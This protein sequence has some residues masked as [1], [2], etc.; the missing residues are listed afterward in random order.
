MD[1]HALLKEV[2]RLLV[3]A[4]GLIAFAWVTP[5]C[6]QYRFETRSTD[7]GL[8][9]NTV[10]AILQ[11]RDG[12]MWFTTS[13]GLV[14][15]D[16]V[17]FVVFDK[18]TTPGLGSN[19]FLS[20]YEDAD[21][22]L[23]AGTADAGVTQYQKGVFHTFSV[24]DGLPNA[25]VIG[26]CDDER[27][28]VLIWTLAGVV[29][30]H[31]GR[32]T[33]YAPLQKATGE[34]TRVLFR[35]RNGALWFTNGAVLWRLAQENLQSY[36]QAEGLD[37]A[38][39][40]SGSEDRDGRI[41]IATARGN[42]FEL[43]GE[44]F[45]HISL[46]SPG[47]SSAIWA[48][49]EDAHSNIVW[50]AT[51][52][53]LLRLSGDELKL[54]TT[55][56]GLPGN[57][58]NTL[59][60]DREGSL[61]VGTYNRG[62]VR[63]RAQAAQ[64]LSKDDGL[65]GNNVYPIVEDPTGA[66]WIGTWDG[67]LSKYSNGKFTSFHQPS[68]PK[69]ITALQSDHQGRLWIGIWGGVGRM[70]DDHFVNLTATLGV[71][72]H[73]VFAIFEDRNGDFWFGTRTGLYRYSGAGPAIRYGT[74]DG[75]ASD[76]VRDII[77]DRN[78]DIWIGSY[79]G[80]TRWHD[81]KFTSLTTKDGLASNTVR[82]LYEDAAGTLWIGTYDGGL[83]RFRDGKFVNYTTTDGLFSNGIFR[84]LED[85]RGNF[86][87]SCNRGIFRVRRDQL[88]DF[89]AGRI[90]RLTCVPYGKED[91]LAQT[92]CNG[93]QQPA[94]IKT[95]DGKLWFPTQGG[96]V[97]IDPNEV[98]T[99]SMAPPVV[100]E[101]ASLDRQPVLSG[102]SLRIDPG[103]ENLEIRYTGLSFINSEHVAFRYRME[104]LENDWVEAGARRTAQYA[105]LPPGHYTFRVIAANA[106]GVWN[107][108][109][110]TLQIIVVPP[111]WRTWWFT[112]MVGVT[113][114][115]IAYAFYRVQISRLQRSHAA[116]RA[117]SQQLIELQEG[118]RK[119]IAAGLH[120]SLG[121]NLLIIK[122]RALLGLQGPGNHDGV[123]NQ[124]EEISGISSQT[125]DEVREIAHALHP[126]QMERLGLTKAI[127]SMLRNVADVSDIIFSTEIDN[128]DGLFPSESEINIYRIVQES[129]NNILKHSGAKSAR[130]AI[131]RE[132]R[133]VLIT[134]A[135]DGRG[136]SADAIA[137]Q[138]SSGGFGL[139]GM[140]ERARMLGG[141]Q[142]VQSTPGGGTTLMI[143]L[144]T[145][146]A[147]RNGQ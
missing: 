65:S 75:L 38:N 34:L 60:K 49:T 78:G 139:R 84:V 26:I 127:Q 99:N 30:W 145:Q 140:A 107:T 9:Q 92:E 76:D 86:W 125:L 79:G 98:T 6:A 88:E 110:A 114:L 129:V 93:G 57:Q 22:T 28:G 10:Q 17:R 122:N 109:G 77:E 81:G 13:D 124:L 41:L 131:K 16:G 53:G 132:P 100:I 54:F 8:P 116:Q 32:F 14:R 91:G 42:I 35:D 7:N 62:V 45:N 20:L 55:G 67:G 95:H 135:D 87:M 142:T 19:R 29:D 102:P 138:Q 120:D 56:D 4:N 36:T 25:K 44:R 64:S 119:R 72:G 143:K 146:E 106:D 96:V 47:A 94:G 58:L 71:T 15:F 130:I 37:G 103:R 70:E 21:G 113:L 123:R 128:I 108:T 80:L 117:F 126:Y 48:M 5:V 2:C 1:L 137:N 63:V 90:R 136:F 141:K 33:P 50:M 134:I 39:V 118:E 105:H 23:W 147:G 101:D 97:V 27:G 61:W 68:F 40:T 144:E 112:I 12:Y 111:F 74:S 89:A 3:I 31:D 66:I 51:D 115:G 46:R 104:G 43:A 82:S 85:A 59:Y 24:A 52:A 11:T 133:T 121:Q 83:S 73:P 69:L 18:A